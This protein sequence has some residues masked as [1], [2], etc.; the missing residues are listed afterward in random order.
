MGK[1]RWA[2]VLV[3]AVLLI[4]VV[5]RAVRIWHAQQQY[6][7]CLQMLRIVQQERRYEYRSGY[8]V[9]DEWGDALFSS[10]YI[11]CERCRDAFAKSLTFP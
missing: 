6:T 5:V 8:Y 11:N 9:L 2:V 3:V 4:L 7:N 10:T 1:R